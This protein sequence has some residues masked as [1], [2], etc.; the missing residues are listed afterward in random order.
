M[1]EITRL[2]RQDEHDPW[3]AETVEQARLGKRDQVLQRIAELSA[4][5]ICDTIDK[6]E[7][8]LAACGEDHHKAVLVQRSFSA[9][10][11]TIEGTNHYDR[12]LHVF[13]NSL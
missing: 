4:C 3:I 12:A 7:P 11:D 5:E 10:L 2:R 13:V 1:D 6:Y 8:N 9:Y